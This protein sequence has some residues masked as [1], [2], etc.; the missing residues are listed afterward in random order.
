MTHAADQDPGLQPV[1]VHGHVTAKV[2][3]SVPTAPKA[4][5]F[6]AWQTYTLAATT[7]AQLILPHDEQRARAVIIVAGTGPVFVGTKAQ[8]QASP[9]LGGSLA[10]GANVETRNRQELWL[11]PDGTHTATVTV[12]TERWGS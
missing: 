8:C 4:A 2:E 11:A 1:P 9:V 10:T 6:G 5:D 12:L 7:A 3:G